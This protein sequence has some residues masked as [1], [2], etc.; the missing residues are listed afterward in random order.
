MN[1]GK[2]I[3][4]QFTIEYEILKIRKSFDITKFPQE[5]QQLVK[6]YDEYIT[7]SVKLSKDMDER[8]TILERILK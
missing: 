1:N 4:R 2:I 7:N 6:L 5:V 3:K 8:I